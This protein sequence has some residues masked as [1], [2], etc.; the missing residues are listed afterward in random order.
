MLRVFF[1]FRDRTEKK[2]LDPT[3]P[4]VVIRPMAAERFA[5]SSHPHR[6]RAQIP[7]AIIQSAY[8]YHTGSLNPMG[9]TRFIFKP[10]ANSIPVHCVFDS[11]T[12]NLTFQFTEDFNVCKKTTRSIN[13]KVSRTKFFFSV[14][15]TV[16]SVSSSFLR[17]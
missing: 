3:V 2:K 15:Q 12:G 13:M 4:T 6:T 14:F 10:I 16:R 1:F 17:R 11:N 7:L 8:L 5:T 9:V